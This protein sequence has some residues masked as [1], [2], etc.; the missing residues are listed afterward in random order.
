MFSINYPARNS[1]LLD[2][3]SLQ[4]LSENIINFVRN[5]IFFFHWLNLLEFMILF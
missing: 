5:I 3:L 4:N 1:R 2:S